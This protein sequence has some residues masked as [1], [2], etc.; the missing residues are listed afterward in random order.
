MVLEAGIKMGN[1]HRMEV[2]VLLCIYL[3]NGICGTALPWKRDLCVYI[4]EHEDLAG[5][6]GNMLPL[7]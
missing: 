7:R 1:I 6:M 5:G 4:W 2:F 3:G